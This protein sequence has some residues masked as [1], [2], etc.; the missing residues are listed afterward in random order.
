MLYFTASMLRRE[1][2]FRALLMRDGLRTIFWQICGISLWGLN[3]RVGG[4]AGDRL[5]IL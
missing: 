2:A 1:H 5:K 3:N 4:G